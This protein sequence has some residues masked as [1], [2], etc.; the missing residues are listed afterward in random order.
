MKNFIVLNIMCLLLCT[1]CSHP[2]KKIEAE[3]NGIRKID[4]M[5][6]LSCNR[7]VNLSCIASN[8]EYS[9]LETDE[10]FLVSPTMNVYC[11]EDYIITIGLQ[12][13]NHDV[14]YIFNRKTGSFVRQISRKGQGPG[15]FTETISSYWDEKKEQ[16]CTWN[17]KAYLFF[18]LDGILSNILN[19]NSPF[20]GNNFVVFNNTL[21]RSAVVLYPKRIFL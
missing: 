6:N 5:A 10:K 16:I 7:I 17:G 3:Y 1:N 21:V 20:L 14:C 15:E 11:S 4:I 19:R 18:N 9:M 2:V 8:I 12:S 13:T